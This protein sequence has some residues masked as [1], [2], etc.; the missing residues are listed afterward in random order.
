M[1]LGCE[2]VCEEAKD[3]QEG[4]RYRG[5]GTGRRGR[6]RWLSLGTHPRDG[7]R[8]VLHASR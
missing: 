3:G 4:S 1:V 2:F 6:R 5:R 7:E 8:N